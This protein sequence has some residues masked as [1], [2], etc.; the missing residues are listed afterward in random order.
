M[1]LS[2]L[3]PIPLSPND[4]LTSTTSAAPMVN[5]LAKNSRVTQF[6][7]ES[8]AKTADWLAIVALSALLIGSWFYVPADPDLWG[9]LRFGLD[10]VASGQLATVDPYAYTTNGQFWTNHEWM[11]EW[12]FANCYLAAGNSGLLALRAVL[13]G[14]TVF[15][16]LGIVRQRDIRGVW[17]LGLGFVAITLLAGLFRVRPQMFSYAF[18]AILMSLCDGYYDGKKRWIWLIPFLMVAWTNFHAGFVAGLGIFGFYWIT[19][20]VTAWRSGD[21]QELLSLCS[22]MLLCLLA[23]MCNPYGFHYWKYVLFAVSL[24]RPSIAEWWPITHHNSTI[25]G[26]Y[27]I[28]AFVPAILCWWNGIRSSVTNRP[29]EVLLF[30]LGIYMAGK[31]G[32]HLAFLCMFSLVFCASQ[33]AIFRERYRDLAWSISKS[34]LAFGVLFLPV[35]VGGLS[36]MATAAFDWREPNLFVSA[37]AY[38]VKA[39]EFLE[40]NKI[41]GNLDCGFT[42]GEYC[43]F[44]LHP[45]CKVFCDGRYETVYPHRVSELVLSYADDPQEW[46]E[47]IGNYPTEIVMTESSGRFRDWLNAGSDFVLIYSDQLAT[48]FVKNSP[49]YRDIIAKAKRREL[50]LPEKAAGNHPFPG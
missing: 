26:Y 8:F 47:R 22:I 17:L 37:T 12:A 25:I 24:D 38:P 23:T 31:H 9:H 35:F 44:R 3:Y 42:W 50:V 7:D 48:V 36:R 19:F 46:A 45:H 20:V 29:A 27:L 49:K 2:P 33:C 32:R 14:V 43:L 18:A 5:Q 30:L 41:H 40:S 21:R 16:L 1:F 4:A 13:L 15:L 34:R 6:G 11:T 39:V 28:M 10:H